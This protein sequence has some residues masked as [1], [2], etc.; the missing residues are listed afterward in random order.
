MFGR[1][2]LGFLLVV[3]LL[4]G[5]AGLGWYAYNAGVVQGLAQ[6]GA[7]AAPSAGAPIPAPFYAYGPSLWHP[8]GLGFGMLGCLFPLLIL[9][10]VFPLMRFLFWRGTGGFGHTGPGFCGPRGASGRE[11]WRRH[12]RERAEEWHRQAHAGEAPK[13]PEGESPRA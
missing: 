10:L 7:A 12:F 11:G 2:A 3:A 4:A 5:V 13:P 1:I 9:A 8:F 6:A